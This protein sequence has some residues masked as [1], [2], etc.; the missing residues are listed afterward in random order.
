[1]RHRITATMLGLLAVASVT[2]IGAGSPAS[3]CAVLLVPAGPGSEPGATATTQLDLGCYPTFAEA[4]AAGSGGAIDLPPDAEPA[5]L[6]ESALEAA[7]A[8]ITTNV[9]IGTEYTSTS[10]LGSS[11]SYFA[12]ETCS[13]TLTW[14]VAYVGDAWNDDFESGKGFGSC[15]HNKKFTASNFGGSVL[16]CTPN[17]ADYGSFRNLISSLRWKD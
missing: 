12:S 11:N 15:D 5:T 14:E 9:M 16:T 2:A 1:M 7:T 8:D 17:C 4:V 10:Y 13:A 6:T 3:N